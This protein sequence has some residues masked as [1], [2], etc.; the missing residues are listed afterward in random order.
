MA[1]ETTANAATH[2]DL[3]KF[4]PLTNRTVIPYGNG[5]TSNV[6]SAEPAISFAP[7]GDTASA[8]RPPSCPA[9]EL[10]FWPV[11]RS[12]HAISRPSPAEKA[13]EPS[14]AQASA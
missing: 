9:N 12:Q 10:A 11:L 3:N 8:F 7:S 1:A 13:R 14:G 5:Q 6:V 2:T 4:V